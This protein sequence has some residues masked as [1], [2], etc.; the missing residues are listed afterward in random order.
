MAVESKAGNE[1][2]D[3]EQAAVLVQ[4]KEDK[5]FWR[6][7]RERLEERQHE[8]NISLMYSYRPIL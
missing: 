2:R 1:A 8:L 3:I 7:G 4:T 6:R 5:W